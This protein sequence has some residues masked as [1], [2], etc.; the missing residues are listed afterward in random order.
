MWLLAGANLAIW[1]SI[2]QAC[3]AVMWVALYLLLDTV[4]FRYS[5]E[6]YGAYKGLLRYG[7][8]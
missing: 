7:D 4:D 3:K 5:F 6:D 1:F 2:E 8:Q